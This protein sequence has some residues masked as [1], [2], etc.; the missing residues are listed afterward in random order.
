M[1]CERVCLKVFFN[2]PDI[3]PP[4]CVFFS[5]LISIRQRVFV[6]RYE[7]RKI[8]KAIPEQAVEAHKVVRR[9]GFHIL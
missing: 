5:L 4:L 9:R 2:K 6:K 7:R 1:K 8:G 3:L